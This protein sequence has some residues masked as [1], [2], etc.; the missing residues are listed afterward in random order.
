[1]NNTLILEMFSLVPRTLTPEEEDI[2]NSAMDK[3]AHINN[4]SDWQKLVSRLIE[5]HNVK[6]MAMFWK[7]FEELDVIS[8][9]RVKDVLVHA[10]RAGIKNVLL[11]H[12]ERIEVMNDPALVKYYK[13]MLPDYEK[14]L[15][16]Q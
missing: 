5:T 12:P 10:L 3:S 4:H 1:V 9:E 15:N 6:I 7:F 13:E 8:D 2:L 14:A 16:L 11:K